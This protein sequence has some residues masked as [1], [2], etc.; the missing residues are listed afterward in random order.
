MQATDRKQD[1]WA[2]ADII[3]RYTRQQAIE[4]GVLVDVTQVAREAGFRCSVALTAGVWATVNE[5]PKSLRGIQDVQGRL[6]DVLW[7]ARLAARRAAA[8]QSVVTYGMIMHRVENKRML[9]NL[10]LKL[11][12]GPGDNGELVITIM[13]PGED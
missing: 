6:W 2:D 7:M 11:H 13:L 3:H 8:G 10:Q 4:D 9:R 1:I 5:I 12:A